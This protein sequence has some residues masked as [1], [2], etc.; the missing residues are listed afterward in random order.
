MGG[1]FLGL[2]VAIA[3]IF[4]FTI[5]G[6]QAQED[7][8]YGPVAELHV[9]AAFLGRVWLSNALEFSVGRE[10]EDHG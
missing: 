3:C 1:W 2:A 10:Y 4:L 6:G 5:E 9:V 8:V 7:G